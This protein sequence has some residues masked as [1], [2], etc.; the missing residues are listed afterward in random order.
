MKIEAEK[1][2]TEEKLSNKII[3]TEVEMKKI[4]TKLIE[5]RKLVSE[6][7]SELLFAKIKNSNLENKMAEINE[8][9]RDQ[10]AYKFKIGM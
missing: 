5:E 7:N 1:I 3:Q 6:I 4:Q 2:N 9:R 10:A 8:I